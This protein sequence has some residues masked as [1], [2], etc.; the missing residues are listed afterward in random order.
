MKQRHVK[1]TFRISDD[2][3]SLINNF[4]NEFKVSKNECITLFLELGIERAYEIERGAIYEE[5]D[6]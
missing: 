3:S 6:A 1:V 4:S 5:N 2:L